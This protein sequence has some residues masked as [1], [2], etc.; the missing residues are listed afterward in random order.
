MKTIQLAITS[1]IHGYLMPTTFRNDVEPLGLIKIAHEIEQ[2]RKSTPTLLI[3]NGDLIQGSPLTYYH[4]KYKKET[5]NPVIQLA[6][7]LNYDAAV[8][9]NHE[10]NFGQAFL[11]DAI[12]QSTF[13]WLAANIL[14]EQGESITRPYSIKE[15][16]GIRI[17][18]IG[19]TTHVVT[20]WEEPEHIKGWHFKDAYES[21][22]KWTTY[23]REFEDVDLIVLCYHGGFAHD[24]STGKLIDTDAEE[25]QGYQMCRDLDFDIFITGHQHRE[26]AQKLFGKSV[27]QP[28]S[29]GTCLGVVRIEIEEDVDGN[30][31]N[32]NH[33]PSLLY[34]DLQ[35]RVN[36]KLVDVIRPIYDET[37]RWLDEVMGV[38]EGDC[39]FEEA[40]SV[41]VYKHPYIELI[42]KIQLEVSG[43]QISCTALFHD[44][45]GGF[46]SNVTMRQIV[47]N[48]I[49][50]NTLK[51]LNVS[52]KH[53]V[54][55][56]EQNATYFTIENGQLTV[57]QRF[58]NPKAQPYNYDMWEGI[59]YEY[60]IREPIGSRVKNVY[61]EGKPL[62]MDE[63]YHVVMNNYRAIGA[64]NFPYFAEAEVVKDIQI[65][66]T[67]LIANYFAKYPT[68]QATCNR[69]WKVVY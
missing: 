63:Y 40:F 69:N 43:A 41:R 51:V 31:S 64:G 46:P 56:L 23:L 7:V 19:V 26:I 13:P 25:N 53:I 24:L 58:I 65:D 38:I 6:N 35:T 49:Y 48:Y 15:I 34:V 2:L 11:K 32:I 33:E 67:E 39:L 4:N 27:I 20:R 28:G 68:I 62:Q 1:D 36:E 61:F 9:G 47:T 8:F 55:A 29:K 14:D 60:H 22:K 16:D 30:V 18:I 5:A 66:M 17:G 50:P 10:F 54:E 57:A 21:A 59:D 52:G 44:G 3:D 37:E 45:P 12:N 42:Q